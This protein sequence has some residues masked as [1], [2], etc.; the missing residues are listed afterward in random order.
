MRNY[1]SMWDLAVQTFNLCCHGEWYPI[2]TISSAIVFTNWHDQW[3]LFHSWRHKHH[4]G[5]MQYEWWAVQPVRNINCHF[6][7]GKKC[8]MKMDWKLYI[9]WLAIAVP[10]SLTSVYECLWNPQP[11]WFECCSV[12]G[13]SA[14]PS[15]STTKA[16]VV[17]RRHTV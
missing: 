3:R 1:N 12:L 8:H 11:S 5:V 4:L 2:H 13:C 15:A 9:A 6:H 16:A 7:G 10:C 14:F 17:E